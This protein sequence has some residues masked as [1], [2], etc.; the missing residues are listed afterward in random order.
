MAAAQPHSQL[1]VCSH[2][3]ALGLEKEPSIC[4]YSSRRPSDNEYASTAPAQGAEARGVF[5]ERGVEFTES[6]ERP[7]RRARRARRCSRN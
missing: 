5:G 7:R 1:S 4:R 3:A 6:T 2:M